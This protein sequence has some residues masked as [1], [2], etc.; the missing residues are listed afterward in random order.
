LT[1]VIEWN[2]EEV[3]DFPTLLERTPDQSPKGL[4]GKVTGGI[5][6][7][8]FVYMLTRVTFAML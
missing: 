6:V 5:G 7:Y 1:R 8:A 3:H 4:W 2:V